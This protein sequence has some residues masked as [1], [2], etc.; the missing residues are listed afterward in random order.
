MEKIENI[1]FPTDFSVNS[2]YAFDYALDLAK[3]YGTRLYILHVVHELIDTTGYYVPN[4]SLVELQDDLLKGA[5]EMMEKFC[6]DRMG[7]FENFETVNTIGLPHL[8]ILN[9]AKDNGVGMIV[10]GTHGRTGIDRVLFG[11]VAE[12]VVK[13]AL[14]PVLTVRYQG[15]KK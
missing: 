5:K 7:D 3:K 13:K 12:K 10:M 14:C 6:K 8:E 9:F 11:S 1:L 4:V 15:S 2:S